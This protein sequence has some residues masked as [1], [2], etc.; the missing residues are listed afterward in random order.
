MKPGV[1]H[2]RRESISRPHAPVPEASNV[3]EDANEKYHDQ[4]SGTSDMIN[5]PLYQ[6]PE[7]SEKIVNSSD[8]PIM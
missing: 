3:N 1:A 4:K 7:P 6:L 2:P 5:S 8:G